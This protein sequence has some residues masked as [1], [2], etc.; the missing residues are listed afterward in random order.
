VSSTA[1]GSAL[2]EMLYEDGRTGRVRPLMPRK[3]LGISSYVTSL[4][5]RV[6][7][8]APNRL[9]GALYTA[10]KSGRVEFADGLSKLRAQMGAFV[11]VETKSGSLA[12]GNEDMSDYDH[13]V[14]A[15]MLAVIAAGNRGYGEYRYE[16]S[17]G[18]VWLSKAM[19]VARRGGSEGMT[20]GARP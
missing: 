18:D 2:Y 10:F 7:K 1:Y 9:A 16:D 12:F 19:A 14:V 20:L 17:S 11:P 13:S 5:P 3:P 8:V 6:E 4:D 15:L